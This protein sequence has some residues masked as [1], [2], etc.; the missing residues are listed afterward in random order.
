MFE[1]VIANSDQPHIRINAR[2]YQKDSDHD[3]RCP[4]PCCNARMKFIPEGVE[5]GSTLYR[6]AHFA[7]IRRAHHIANC[8]ELKA[9][10]EF[11]RKSIS[12][13]KAVEAGRVIIFSLNG[14][15]GFRPECM[16][17]FRD[18][19]H[20]KEVDTPYNQ[21]KEQCKHPVTKDPG[22]HSHSVK[23]IQ[24]LISAIDLIR[25]HSG[26]EIFQNVHVTWQHHVLPYTDFYIDTAEKQRELF[27]NLYKRAGEVKISRATSAFRTGITNRDF[28]RLFRFRP[29]LKTRNDHLRNLMG[30]AL[31]LVDEHPRTKVP[32]IMQQQISMH[33]AQ[34][35]LDRN[36]F[37]SETIIIASPSV[38]YDTTRAVFDRF[39]GE[40][41]STCFTQMLLHVTAATQ[42]TPAVGIKLPKPSKGGQKVLI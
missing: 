38:A 28:P 8:P 22:H 40:P 24:E 15:F 6:P 18:A 34:T 12:L 3:L 10:I 16:R 20:A 14:V 4:N 11:R 2:I 26:N 29:S 41:S 30:T 37:S 9:D 7:S 1:V 21:L 13:R 32:L 35:V 19:V 42:F 33:D 36:V 23:S 39:H 31:K 25:H 17:S 27:R 5:Q